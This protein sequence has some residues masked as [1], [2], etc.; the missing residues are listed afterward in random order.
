M[1]TTS[2]RVAYLLA[3]SKSAPKKQS[4]N[5]RPRRLLAGWLC[6]EVVHTSV[7]AVLAAQRG[8]HSSAATFLCRP[9]PR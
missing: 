3:E 8:H 5:R 9:A 7:A 2:Y 6:K 4:S 1:F